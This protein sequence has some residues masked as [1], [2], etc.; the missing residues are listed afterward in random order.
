MCR[1]QFN[2]AMTSIRPPWW[3][4][5]RCMHDVQVY[6]K[7]VN[8]TMMSARSHCLLRVTNMPASKAGGH[9]L[10][11][12]GLLVSEELQFVDTWDHYSIKEG[13]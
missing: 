3:Q 10:E 4:P 5:V 6:W 13:T 12:H 7:T 9:K 2:A 11:V 1:K 8:A